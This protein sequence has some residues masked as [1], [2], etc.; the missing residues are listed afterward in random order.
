MEDLFTI[1]EVKSE[2]TPAKIGQR[3]GMSEDDLRDFH[4]ENC[5]KMGLMW[6]NSFVGIDKI[7]IPKNYKSPAEIKEELKA[8]LPKPFF[9]EDFYAAS[10]RFWKLLTM[11]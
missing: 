2:D 6:F 10:T 11:I 8:A 3:F 9:L 4:N 7:V 5:E 1:Y